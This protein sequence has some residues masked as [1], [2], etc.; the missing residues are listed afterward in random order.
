M[1]LVFKRELYIL[2]IRYHLPQR[3][4]EVPPRFRVVYLKRIIITLG[5]GAGGNKICSQLVCHVHSLPEHGDRPSARIFATGGQGAETEILGIFDIHIHC[6]EETKGADILKAM[7]AVEMEKAAIFSP[8]THETNETE[9]ESIEV[10]TRVVA[11]DPER[12]VGFAW[13]EPT[14]SDAADHVE[15]AVNDKGL[16]GVKMIPNH[17][18]PY[19]ERLFPVYERIQEMRVPLLFHSGILYGNADSSRGPA[20]RRHRLGR[21][22][23]TLMDQANE[24]VSRNAAALIT[25]PATGCAIDVTA[26]ALNID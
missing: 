23:P 2:S 16:K 20:I 1:G 11:E 22:Q 8:H 7:D 9:I 17:W 19:E 18:Y 24:V 14:L 5:K 21:Y 4:D 15:M 10:V 3:F 25:A 12:L 6:R 26:P 13:I